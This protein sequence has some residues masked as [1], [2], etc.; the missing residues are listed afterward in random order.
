[1]SNIMNYL[2]WRGDLTFE[3]SPFNEVD[4][5]IL[6]QLSYVDFKGIVPG[7]QYNE[8]V[9]LQE[10]NERYYNMRTEKEIQSDKSF[11]RL[12]P[13]LMKKM[14]ETKRFQN[15][16]L[17]KFICKHDYTEEKQFSAIHF[18]L[19]D[20]TIYV[21]YRGTDDTLVG[22]K[23]DFNMSFMTPVP[24]QL[25]AVDYINTTVTDRSKKL[26]LGG[27]SKGGNLAIYAGVYGDIVIKNNIIHI[28]NNDGPGF[29]REILQNPL[30]KNMLPRITTIVPESSIVGMLLEHEEDYKIVK[31]KQVS[32]MQHDAMS[33]EVLGPVFVYCEELS[34]GSQI[35]DHTIKSWLDG[36]ST[37]QRELFIDSLYSILE[38]TGAK[39][40]SDL[41]LAKFKNINL[42]L[43]SFNAL[44]ESTKNMLVATVKQLT[45]T[46]YQHFKSSIG[47]LKN[48]KLITSQS[49]T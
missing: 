42:V 19:D 24:S 1:M 49:T 10:A 18:Y 44:D 6:A 43:K 23:E 15:I 45:S 17:G 47:N 20:E 16:R 8:T 28:Y 36:I 21:A 11:T 37:E 32:F 48:T 30:Y 40:L 38:A 33:W 22:W 4:N 34:H 14:T 9:S 31:S 27:H 39:T 35:L 13:I 12:S 41:S 29:P 46:Y 2:D 7:I 3:Q 5:L 25:E 26:Y